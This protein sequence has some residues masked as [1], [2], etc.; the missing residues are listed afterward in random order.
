MEKDIEFNC[1]ICLKSAKIEQNI[2]RFCLAHSTELQL[3]LGQLHCSFNCQ[4]ITWGWRA[5][6]TLYLDIFLVAMFN[7]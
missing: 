1:Y 4:V 5:Y 6:V 2:Y 7:V 3:T